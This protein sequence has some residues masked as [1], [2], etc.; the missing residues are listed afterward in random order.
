MASVAS[1]PLEADRP[2]RSPPLQAAPGK[3]PISRATHTRSHF[4]LVNVQ[5]LS[6][7]L[8][9]VKQYAGTPIYSGPA[10]GPDPTESGWNETVKMHPGE[11]TTVIMQFNLPGVP[12]DSL[13]V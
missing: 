13:L 3:S 2:P 12:F 6:R 9:D 1:S 5:V 7:Q 10:R 8:F 4:H 11:V